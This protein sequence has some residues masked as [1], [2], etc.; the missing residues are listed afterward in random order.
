MMQNFVV[1]DENE[2]N[3]KERNKVYNLCKPIW[4]IL[5]KYKVLPT[6]DEWIS[7]HY[8]DTALLKLRKG[9]LNFDT[10]QI[11]KRKGRREVSFR[12][13]TLLETS[14]LFSSLLS[15]Q[16]VPIQRENF[17]PRNFSFCKGRSCFGGETLSLFKQAMRI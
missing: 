2:V 13:G 1:V 17:F 10:K 16:S 6:D 12:L 3:M 9:N 8:Y 15:A 7:R 14:L 4:Y 5:V 11:R